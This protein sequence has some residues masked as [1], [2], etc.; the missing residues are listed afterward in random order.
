MGGINGFFEEAVSL[1][2]QDEFM[3]TF[4]SKLESSND[5]SRFFEKFGNGDFG[6]VIEHLKVKLISFNT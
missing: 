2:P 3:M 4:F 6:D 5:F 1:M